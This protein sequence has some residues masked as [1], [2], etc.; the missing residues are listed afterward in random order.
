MALLS[1]MT[2]N[3]TI[4]ARTAMNILIIPKGDFNK[5]RKSV[6]AFGDVFTKLT[7]QRA[8]ARSP[9]ASSTRPIRAAVDRSP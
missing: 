1:D 9:Q 8:V 7:K 4:R 2:R 3:A 6:P 5:L